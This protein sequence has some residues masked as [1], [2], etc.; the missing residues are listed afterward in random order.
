[1]KK[2]LLCIALLSLIVP[3]VQSQCTPNTSITIPGIYPDTSTNLAVAFAGFPYNEVIQVK[4]L[5]DT[6]YNGLPATVQRITVTGVQGLPPGFT[7]TCSPINCVFP[8]G[9]NG[10]ISLVGIPTL[11]NVGTYN[12]KVSVVIRGQITGIPIPVDVP[13]TIKGYRI[14]IVNPVSANQNTAVKYELLTNKPN[15]AVNS[16]EIRFNLPKAAA[17]DLQIFDMLGNPVK[18]MKIQGNAGYNST[19]VSLENMNQGVYFYTLTTSY[20]VLTRR[21]VISA[22]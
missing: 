9:T 8:G 1:M 19:I 10:C 13:D 22:K 5:T 18:K 16:T 20:G 6:T 17:A 4:V 15:P 12:I 14:Q 21:M 7:Y 2:I 3:T 11:A